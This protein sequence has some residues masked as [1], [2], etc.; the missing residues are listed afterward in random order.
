[1][2]IGPFQ[3]KN[4]VLLAPMA[5]VTDRPFRQLC[6]QWD[7]GLTVS[8]MVTSDQKLWKTR[9]SSLRLDHSGEPGPIS[10][11]IAGSDPQQ[12]ADAAIANVERGAQIIDIN[13][14]CPA[15][16]VCNKAAGSA[17][18][19]DEPL[20]ERILVAVV[21]AV[22]VPVTL[23]TRLGSCD[24]RI[25]AP[26][27]AQLAE[28]SGI[29]ALALHGRT[30]QQMYNGAATFD[31]IRQIKQHINIPVIANGDITTPEKAKAV[32]S[33]TGAD[34]IMVGRGAHGR[35]WL[36]QQ[37]NH[38]LATGELLPEP[39]A[40]TIRDTVLG[41]LES[42]YDFYGEVQ[43]VRVARKHLRWYGGGNDES[44]AWLDYDNFWGTVNKVSDSTTQ[45]A[46]TDS[47]LRQSIDSRSDDASLS[48]SRN[49]HQNTK[50]TAR[51]A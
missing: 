41:H 1:M 18:M 2:H 6:R 24:E 21:N 32:L 48:T 34:A 14:G 10:V 37:I 23:K 17:L 39:D 47:W 35:P 40:E 12:L 5:G 28:Q 15:K 44:A 38:Y 27:I 4:N 3:L 13:M 49:T 25:N 29:A 9:K 22:D 51:A 42:L 30:R 20:V 16:K 43:G 19:A 46:L 7:A 26:R 45:F 33:A 11:Q 8:E 36:F 50:I 31:V